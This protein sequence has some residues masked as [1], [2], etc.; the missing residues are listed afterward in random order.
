MITKVQVRRAQCGKGGLL[1]KKVEARK[2]KQ[3]LDSDISNNG[4]DQTFIFISLR[5]SFS[6]IT[7]N[8][9]FPMRSN[10]QNKRPVHEKP[11]LSTAQSFSI[12]RDAKYIMPGLQGVFSNF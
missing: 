11:D 6:P 4:S 3:F 1:G 10:I 9:P 8:C 2:K 12:Q 7:Q 5:F